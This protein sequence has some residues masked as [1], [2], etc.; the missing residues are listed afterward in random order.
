MS[1]AYGQCVGPGEMPIA[2]VSTFRQTS[3]DTFS[4]GEL[5]VTYDL[6]V[7]A[8]LPLQIFGLIQFAHSYDL[9]QNDAAMGTIGIGIGARL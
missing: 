9:D 3:W 1:G 4:G 5:H 6:A 8:R 2:T 7:F